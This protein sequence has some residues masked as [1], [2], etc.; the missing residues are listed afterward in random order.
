[1]TSPTASLCNI[2]RAI[3]MAR[4][5][6]SDRPEMADHG[7]N[8]YLM[9]RDPQLMPGGPPKGEWYCVV[10][11]DGLERYI[12]DDGDRGQSQTSR[13]DQA[14][15]ATFRLPDRH[16]VFDALNKLIGGFES[17]KYGFSTPT[18][19]DPGRA[20]EDRD[21]VVLRYAAAIGH[22]NHTG[23]VTSLQDQHP[24]PPEQVAEAYRTS[25][26]PAHAVRDRAADLR[27][28]CGISGSDYGAILAAIDIADDVLRLSPE[29]ERSGR[30]RHYWQFFHRPIPNLP[31]LWSQEDA[32]AREVAQAAIATHAA[33]VVIDLLE[34]YRDHVYDGLE[35]ALDASTHWEYAWQ[36]YDTIPYLC[37]AQGLAGDLNQGGPLIDNPQRFEAIR[38]DVDEKRVRIADSFAFQLTDLDGDRWQAMRRG[39]AQIAARGGKPAA[40]R[41]LDE[42]IEEHY[43]L[44]R[45]CKRELLETAVH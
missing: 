6:V 22:P 43:R 16:P 18:P 9:R 11:P 19:R 10:S 17:W 36:L 42:L 34:R 33:P 12:R 1:M 28:N 44:P 20:L 40:E 21:L 45:L 24:L 7:V 31:K 23:L 25:P 13:P 27:S 30:A 14:H 3:A 4:A 5:Y 38:R 35:Q 37:A 15:I 41:F 32:I 8:W 29:D 39:L 2:D 26:G